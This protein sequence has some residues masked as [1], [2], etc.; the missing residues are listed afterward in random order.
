MNRTRNIQAM[1]APR[2]QVQPRLFEPYW[3]CCNAVEKIRKIL[4]IVIVDGFRYVARSYLF[5]YFSSQY[6]SIGNDD[7]L[8]QGFFIISQRNSAQENAQGTVTYA[9]LPSFD[10]VP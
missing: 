1:H 5:T 4:A 3:I 6:F 9:L 8:G 2:G 10:R 7:F